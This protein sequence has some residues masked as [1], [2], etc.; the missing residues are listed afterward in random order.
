MNIIAHSG[1]YLILPKYRKKK[2]LPTFQGRMQIFPAW[3]L[4]LPLEA[5]KREGFAAA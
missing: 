1:V 5:W 2:K 3:P 4:A